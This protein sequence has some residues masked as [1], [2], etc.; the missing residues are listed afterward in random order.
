VGPLEDRPLKPK[1]VVLPLEQHA[2]AAAA[3]VVRAGERVK[4]GQLI[5]APPEGKLGANIHA[6]ISGRVSK[7][8]GA[9]TIQA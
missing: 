5:A 8:D 4:E 9:I 2:G 6:S 1:R 3:P 7:V